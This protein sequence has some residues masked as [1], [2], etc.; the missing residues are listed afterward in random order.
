MAKPL[1]IRTKGFGEM[2]FN[3][4]NILHFKSDSSG[5]TEITT[6]DGKRFYT[7]ESFNSIESKIEKL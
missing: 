1:M 7:D 5:T 6:I 2:M 4:D 3:Y